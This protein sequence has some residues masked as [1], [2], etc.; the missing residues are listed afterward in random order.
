MGHYTPRISMIMTYT[1]V[2]QNDKALNILIYLR[3]PVR[4]EDIYHSLRIYIYVTLRRIDW[5]P[6]ISKNFSYFRPSACLNGNIF[7][8]HVMFEYGLYW[9]LFQVPPSQKFKI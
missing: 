6:H 1:K 9:T 5:I 3:I 7:L 2:T 8:S 4:E